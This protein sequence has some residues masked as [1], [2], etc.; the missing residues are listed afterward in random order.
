MPVVYLTRRATFSAAHRLHNPAL[1]DEENRKIYGKCNNPH[2]HGHN[3]TIEITVRGE[4]DTKT[5]MVLNLVDLKQ[6]IET[7]IMDGMDHKHLNLD[8]PVFQEMVPTV[9]NLVVVCWKLLENRLPQGLLHEVKIYETENNI[10]VY[11][12]E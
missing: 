6:A 11:R 3:Y 8:V 5:G 7:T 12:G 10:A 4:I 1:S 9:E 2:G